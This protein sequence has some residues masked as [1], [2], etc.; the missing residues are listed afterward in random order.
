MQ[1]GLRINLTT[2]RRP[3]GETSPDSL[4]GHT[5]SNSPSMETVSSAVH[6]NNGGGSETGVNTPP[7]S[8]KPAFVCVC[9]FLCPSKGYSSMVG[10]SGLVLS[11][12][13]PGLTSD[14]QL[15]CSVCSSSLG[16]LP[17]WFRLRCANSGFCDPSFV[18]PS[19]S[20]PMS[21]VYSPPPT[22][23]PTPPSPPLSALGAIRDMHAQIISSIKNLQ[24]DGE[25]PRKLLQ[26]WGRLRFPRHVLQ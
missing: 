4:T 5:A 14:P 22:P 13:T 9:R 24:L 26:S 10:W 3:P 21:P 11:V 25:D 12:R 17:V 2:P 8:S 1:E 7:P 18:V 16:Y 6:V 19:S 23:A 15:S 20:F